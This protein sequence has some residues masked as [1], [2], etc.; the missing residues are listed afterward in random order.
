MMYQILAE[1]WSSGHGLSNISRI[2][3]FFSY[4]FANVRIS[5]SDHCDFDH[6]KMPTGRI[7]KRARL[8]NECEAIAESHA[9]KAYICFCLDEEDSFED[10]F[11]IM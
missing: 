10:E 7:S 11:V 9:E 1:I 3:D 8:L 5:Q 4:I 2:P 6:P